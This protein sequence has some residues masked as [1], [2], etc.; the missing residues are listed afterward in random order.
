MLGLSLRLAIS[1]VK[2]TFRDVQQVFGAEDL[3]LTQGGDVIMTQNGDF[4]IRQKRP[5]KQFV[6]QDGD[7]LLTQDDRILEEGI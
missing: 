5:A 1:S 3:L 2:R 4:L 7:F 6:T